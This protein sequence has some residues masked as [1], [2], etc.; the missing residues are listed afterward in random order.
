[1]QDFSVRR[2]AGEEGL[3]YRALHMEAWTNPQVISD[4]N[5]L[6]ATLECLLLSLNLL[7]CAAVQDCRQEVATLGQGRP[8]P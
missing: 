8:R 6:F 2:G 1:M 3:R 7:P 5:S 4:C